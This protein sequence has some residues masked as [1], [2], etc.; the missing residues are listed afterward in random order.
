MTNTRTIHG[1]LILT[2]DTTFNESIIVEGNIKGYFDLKVKGDIDC[3]NI[4]CGNIDC[5]NIDCRNI[6]C[7][8]IDCWDI[9]CWDID[10]WDIDC[11]NID[12]WDID[13]RNIDCRN[14]VYCDKIKVRKGCKVICKVLIK[15][16]FSVER[17]EQKISEEKK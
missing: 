4:D 7:R 6:D 5:G 3:V 15:D 8:N 14:I 10:C 9:D 17:K 12:C 11:G 1:D 16:R 13:C 2:K